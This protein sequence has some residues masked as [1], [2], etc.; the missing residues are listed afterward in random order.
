MEQYVKDHSCSVDEATAALQSVGDEA[1]NRAKQVTQNL[2]AVN[3]TLKSRSDYTLQDLVK[4]GMNTPSH[5]R[6]IE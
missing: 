1:A 4:A 5:M 6:M 2:D 3:K